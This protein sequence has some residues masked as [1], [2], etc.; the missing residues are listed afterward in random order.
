M[1]KYL[2]SSRGISVV[3][4]IGGRGPLKAV[5]KEF[6]PSLLKFLAERRRKHGIWY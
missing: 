4:L 1:Q 5:Q 3:P 2:G 6:T